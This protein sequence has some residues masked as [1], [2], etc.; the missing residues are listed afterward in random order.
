MHGNVESNG[1][2]SRLNLKGGGA[3]VYDKCQRNGT[4]QKPGQVGDTDNYSKLNMGQ[5]ASSINGTSFPCQYSV[6]TMEISDV[7]LVQKGITKHSSLVANFIYYFIDLTHKD[8]SIH[9]TPYLTEKW[10]EMGLALALTP[11]QLD[12]IEE[13][14]QGISD[15]FQLWE[16]LAT[17][18][19][20][21]ETLLNA[22]RSPV[23]NEARLANELLSL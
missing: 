5:Q 17:R 2:Y 4:A 14:N 13:N 20:T 11:P 3:P 16:D 21:W 6:V 8:L 19:F 1:T 10:R 12:D 18:P 23:I 9:V 15:V 22:L 7:P